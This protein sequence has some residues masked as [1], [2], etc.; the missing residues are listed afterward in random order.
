MPCRR[1]RHRFLLSLTQAFEGN[2]VSH[3][4]TTINIADDLL[5]KAK[6]Q[7]RREKKTLREVV[8]EAL[9]MRLSREQAPHPFKLR[10]HSFK[11]KGLRPG[12]AEG[13]WKQVRD[14]IYGTR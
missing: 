10:R 2:M 1:F 3:M 6:R 11:G 12:I 7:A 14:L 9:R 8:E 4:R 13:D 5:Y